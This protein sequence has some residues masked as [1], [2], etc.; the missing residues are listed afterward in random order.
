LSW[1]RFGAAISKFFLNEPLGSQPVV[2]VMTMIAS[3]LLVQLVR[4]RCDPLSE[5]S[6]IDVAGLLRH[7]FCA[8]FSSHNLLEKEVSLRQWEHGRW[9]TS[10]NFAISF[11]TIG[12]LIDLYIW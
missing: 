4:L 9:F 5:S 8:C 2:K 10:Q 7:F 11:H 1:F 6:N 3:V 12:F